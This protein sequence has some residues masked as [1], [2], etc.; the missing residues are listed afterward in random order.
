MPKD[1]LTKALEQKIRNQR[2]E[3][4]RLLKAYKSLEQSRDTWKERAKM[5]G[6][7]LFEMLKKKGEV[8]G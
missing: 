5:L 7:Q 2:Q 4:D 6:K 3:I 8:E 1:E